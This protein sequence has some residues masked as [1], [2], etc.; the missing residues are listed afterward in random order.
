MAAASSYAGSAASTP[1]KTIG[2][3]E[4]IEATVR[5]LRERASAKSHVPGWCGTYWLERAEKLLN[6]QRSWF[7]PLRQ[8][9]SDAIGCERAW[10]STQRYAQDEAAVNAAIRD[11]TAESKNLGATYSTTDVSYFIPNKCQYTN[12]MHCFF[13]DCERE[14]KDRMKRKH[15]KSFNYD[16]PPDMLH[17]AKFF[18]RTKAPKLTD[19]LMNL[20]QLR[21]ALDETRGLA[22]G[23]EALSA[24]LNSIPPTS[25]GIESGPKIV[26]PDGYWRYAE[27]APCPHAEGCR[28][29]PCWES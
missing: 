15:A 1:T 3:Q 29:F 10:V 21:H 26:R 16:R 20:Q 9:L 27:E 25:A 11:I 7:A 5:L 17:V 2:R 8:R 4:D 12:C 24:E 13:G 22:R 6:R 23:L 28:R 19:V 14:K 18:Y